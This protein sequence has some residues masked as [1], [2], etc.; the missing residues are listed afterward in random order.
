MDK[1][2]TVGARVLDNLNSSS[3]H[4][5]VSV[6]ELE[7]AMQEEYHNQLLDIIDQDHD[8]Y[9][10]DFYVVVLT[11]NERLIPNGF[12]NYFLTRHSCPTPF[13]DQS[14]FKYNK[15]EGRVEYLWTVPDKQVCEHLAIN[16]PLVVESERWLLSF[17]LSYYNGDLLKLAQKHNKE[18]KEQGILYIKDEKELAA[19]KENKS[20]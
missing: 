19:D 16:A 7:R 18:T 9:S 10:G 8:K 15:L 4:G 6:I 20:V 13:F 1:K 12:R 2:K 5:P 11:K 14:V 17:V 3:E